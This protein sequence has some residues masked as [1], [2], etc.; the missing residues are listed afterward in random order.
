MPEISRFYGIII[1]MYAGDHPPPHFHAVYGEY[2]AFVEIASGRVLYGH[3]PA[4]A[5]RLVQMWAAEHEN[6]LRQDW[7]SAERSEPLAKI[8]PLE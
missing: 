8:A 3:L 7:A 5:L 1:R 4:T 2:E 6:E